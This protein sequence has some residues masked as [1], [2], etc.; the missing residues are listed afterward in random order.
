MF[1]P[2]KTSVPEIVC[3]RCPE[4]SV[5]L[6]RDEFG[7]VLFVI[8]CVLV[9]SYLG[10]IFFHRRVQKFKAQLERLSG[11]I[12]NGSD[13]ERR[14]KEQTERSARIRP[15]LE[16]LQQRL[17]IHNLDKGSSKERNMPILSES[18][19]PINITEQGEVS[20][21][22]G[23]LFD[24][25][26]VDRDGALSYKELNTIL[27]FDSL[28]LNDFVQ[29]MNALGSEDNSG[30]DHVTKTTFM[31][32]FL[33]VL[34]ETS[35]F[36]LTPEEAGVRWD[37]IF[38]IEGA[39][40]KGEIQLDKLYDSS[41]AHF[42]TDVQIKN[43]IL[44]LRKVKLMNQQTS[45]APTPQNHF[46]HG[47]VESDGISRELF[48]E[49]YPAILEEILREQ[50]MLEE[51]IVLKEGIDITFQNLKLVV[52]VGRSDYINVVDDVSGRIQKG[53]MTALLGGSGA[54]KTSLLNALCGRAYYGE[55]QGDVMINGQKASVEDFSDSIGFVPQDDIVF[56]ELTVRENLMYSGR[57]RLPRGTPLYEIEDLADTVLANLGL[58]RKAN[59]IVGDV[60]RRGVSGG[61]K[62]R[63]NIGL[64]LMAKPSALFLDEPTSGLDASSALI[65]MMSLQ[66][67]V[68]K[69][70][71]TI[72]SVIHQPRKFIFELFDSLLLLGVGGRMVYHGPVEDAD[73]Y[74]TSLGYKLPLGESV[75]DW[76][77]DISTG[78][79]AA[80][81][82]P[83][84]DNDDAIDEENASLLTRHVSKGLSMRNPG[85]SSRLALL[86]NQGGS[87]QNGNNTELSGS[88]I[89]SLLGAE[90]S[91]RDT[92][93]VTAAGP[94][95]NKADRA[96]NEAKIR[97]ELLYESWRDHFEYIGDET[98]KLF[99]PPEPYDFPQK[100]IMPTFWRQFFLQMQRT[101]LLAWRNRVTKTI[102]TS[103]IVFA[104]AIITFLD[105]SA[106]VS[107]DSIPLVPF[108]AFIAGQEEVISAFFKPLFE[109]SLLGSVG[110]LR[111]GASVGVIASVLIA[112][113]SVK[114]ITEKRLEFF[115]EAGS[116]Y[117]TN[118]Y[119]LAVN[120]FTS[121]DQGGQV[122]L[123]AIIA[124]WV[125]HSISDKPVFYVA[126][127][128]LAWI[129]VSWS[130]FIALIAPPK[131]TLVLLGFFMAFFGLLF[132]GTTP[133]VLYKGKER[134]GFFL[135]IALVKLVLS[136]SCLSF[137]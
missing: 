47:S 4:G 6:W 118:A 122:L 7:I 67:L 61:E 82:V 115:R 8:F 21:D 90:P 68:Q 125:R 71:V 113:M 22:A 128:L 137:V 51:K 39:N 130:L 24:A 134:V 11:R 32:N 42:L 33:D 69:Q 16:I 123:A 58:S 31:N 117:D 103:I 109:F 85:M 106:S 79:V 100:T 124:Q 52:K 108:E 36:R 107:K 49:H 131:N 105:G 91:R 54:G 14:A 20:F 101:V 81:S 72:C 74:F 86:S 116:G 12:L 114:A 48:C 17:E 55:V 38:D 34:E 129:S 126:F 27:Q 57:F 133:P 60:T 10:T 56:A 18:I 77:I 13:L 29:R 112:L 70:G 40:S 87:S 136:P 53:T 15:K 110:Y 95:S 102:E 78:R 63:V 50:S 96:E 73:P 43:V 1:C 98:K 89:V 45:T 132:G 119:F 97:R 65:V 5:E 120:I 99:N 104:V 25:I 2:H 88:T 41:I 135:M 3:E 26:D 127:L 46:F 84:D 37:E 121:F 66:Q 94:S 93:V 28:E 83:E 75:A 9:G 64:E 19:G 30:I 92:Q 59:S 80:D 76:L 44:A 62:K 23:E 111:Y 35:N